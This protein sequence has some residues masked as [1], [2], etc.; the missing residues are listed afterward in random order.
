M[1]E[2]I[3]IASIIQKEA[4]NS[5]QMKIISSII[6]NRLR[7]SVAFP[8]LGCDSTS[9][10]ISNYVTQVVGGVKGSYY[11]SK[12]D[13]SAVKGLPP[14]PICNPGADAIEAALYPDST[15]YYF[16]LHDNSGKIYLAKTQ[17]EHESNYVKAIKANNK[18]S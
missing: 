13:T 2:I 14:G 11:L 16:F 7:N 8:T 3:T 10:Y 17:K 5:E 12:Y 6:H 18:N 9:V 15:D 4:A 1:D